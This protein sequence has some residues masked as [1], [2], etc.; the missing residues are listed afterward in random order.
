MSIENYNQPYCYTIFLNEMKY[1][2]FCSV[3]LW[4]GFIACLLSLLSMISQAN[5]VVKLS[6]LVYEDQELSSKEE[7]LKHYKTV[8]LF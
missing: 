2:M 3:L 7:T 8:K 1:P 5:R 4:I 6:N